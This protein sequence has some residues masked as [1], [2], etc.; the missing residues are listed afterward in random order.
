MRHRRLLAALGLALA[1][2]VCATS[3]R[4]TA[5]LEPTGVIIASDSGSD[6]LMA[7]AFLLTRRDARI[8]AIT[9]V[10]GLAHVRPG[11]ANVLRLLE[12]AGRSDIP[13]YVGRETPLKPTAEFP[14]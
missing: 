3:A 9:I 6:D 5:P 11:A 14:K 7:I 1:A 10:N 4:R 2:T 12:L 8:E 13:V